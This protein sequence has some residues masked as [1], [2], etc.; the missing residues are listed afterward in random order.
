MAGR[1]KRRE[2]D[3]FSNKNISVWTSALYDCRSKSLLLHFSCLGATL[4]FTEILSH[5]CRSGLHDF[6]HLWPWKWCE[7]LSP[8]T[9]MG[10]WIHL[11]QSVYEKTDVAL[12]ADLSSS[13]EHKPESVCYVCL[14]CYGQAVSWGLY[15]IIFAL[16]WDNEHIW[17]CLTLRVVTNIL[18]WCVWK[19][20]TAEEVKEITC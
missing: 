11:Q 18:I 12:I 8:V 10:Q 7:R 20:L 15:W 13:C 14:I 16:G 5:V 2:E 9:W 6:I 19:Y 4:E 17:P 1:P 3:G